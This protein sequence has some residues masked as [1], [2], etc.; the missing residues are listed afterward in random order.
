MKKCTKIVSVLLICCLLMPACMLGGTKEETLTVFMD[1]AEALFSSDGVE[2]KK[3]YHLRSLDGS[4]DFVIVE[5]KKTGY[6]IF[7]KDTMAL[8]EYTLSDKSPYNKGSK[9]SYYAG[10][11]NYYTKENGTFTH[12]VLDTE[13]EFDDCK[14]ISDSIRDLFAEPD[15]E[16]AAAEPESILT[17]QPLEG[18][19]DPDDPETGA[20]DLTEPSPDATYIENAWYFQANPTHAERDR[21]SEDPMGTCTVIAAQL[22][23]GYHNYF[24]D[25]RL[26]PTELNGV[27]T[28]YLAADYGALDQRNNPNTLGTQR[29]FYLRLLDYIDGPLPLGQ[30]LG[31]LEIGANNYL[32]DIEENTGE[33][34]DATILY[35]IPLVANDDLIKMAVE[36]EIN[37]DRP[38]VL[39]MDGNIVNTWHVVV[40]YGYQTLGNDYGYIVHFGWQEDHPHAWTNAEWYLHFVT[41]EVDHT[42]AYEYLG[43]PYHELHCTECGQSDIRQTHTYTNRYAL[44]YTD[45]SMHYAY[46]T[47]G[48]Y[49]FQV[50]D[51]SRIN[52]YS[53]EYHTVRC[54]KCFYQTKEEHFFKNGGDIC[55]LCRY[56]KSGLT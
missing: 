50:H 27:P 48:A 15:D 12:T 4:Y 23:L 40:C 9:K 2:P 19:I 36:E 6:A 32:S 30:P 13:T 31:N 5:F 44:Y 41:M 29:A 8:L 17:Q 46:C 33:Q 10:P 43:G 22:L 20:Q 26:I 1:K 24:S 47:C 11:G 49:E 18:T 7:Y 21:N 55:V 38:I 39:G 54:K 42:H 51:F 45:T 53:P 28:E 56:D 35:G 37:A 25:R 34:I 52:S 14:K 3:A 16:S